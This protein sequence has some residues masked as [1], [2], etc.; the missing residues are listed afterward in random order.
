MG[1]T[2]CQTFGGDAACQAA[3]GTVC[4]VGTCNDGTCDGAT[5]AA[6]CDYVDAADN[7]DC[8]AENAAPTGHV[9]SRC[10]RIGGL[11]QRRRL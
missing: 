7:T 5:A 2:N 10:L 8:S 1:L 4:Q 6:C 3:G 11:H 9:S